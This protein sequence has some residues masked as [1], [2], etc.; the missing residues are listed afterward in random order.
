MPIF[1]V[2][3]PKIMTY[4]KNMERIKEV[5]RIVRVL[6][7]IFAALVLISCS[8]PDP[9]RTRGQLEARPE[10]SEVTLSPGDVLEIKFFYVP[11]LNEIQTVRPD[12]KVVLQLVGEVAIEGKSPAEVMKDLKARYEPVLKKP[13]VSVIVRKL[14]ARRVYVGGQVVAPGPV[15]LDGTLFA[16]EAIH[17]AGGFNAEPASVK[18]VVIIRHKNGQRYGA[19]LDFRKAL[20]GGEY[21]PFRLEPRDIIYVPKTSIAQV[22]TW[23]DQ[24]I[25]KIVPKLGVSASFPAGDATLGLNWMNE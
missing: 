10:S 12:G 1:F 25:N 15:D 17:F 23:I 18:N 24:H 7:G 20:A 14:A 13:E 2:D 5:N 16:L 8:S 3:L 9:A 11:E 4:K 19:A 21:R 6:A 22:N